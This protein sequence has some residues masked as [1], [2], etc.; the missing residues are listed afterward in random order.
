MTLQQPDTVRADWDAID[1]ALEALAKAPVLLVATDY[2]GTLAPIVDDPAQ[3][4]PI[5][6]SL[7]ALRALTALPHTHVAAVSGR[8]LADLAKLS[9]LDG[10]VML[11]GSHG[12]EFDQDFAGAITPQQTALRARLLD[13]LDRVASAGRGFSVEQ[14][15]ASIAFHYRNADPAEADRV[16]DELRAGPGSWPGVHVKTGKKVLELA[17]IHTSKGDAI[18]TIRHRVGA[19]AVLYLGDDVTDEDAFTRLRGPDVGVKVGP[20]ETAAALRVADTTD[21]ARLLA[22]LVERRQSWLAGA[23]AVP[24]EQHTLLSDGRVLALVA[25]GARLTWMCVPR[26][27]GPALFADLLGGP[28]AGHF[29]VEPTH[30]TATPTARYEGDSLVLRTDWPELSVTD[31]LDCSGGKPT[32]RAGR[33]DLIRYLEGRGEVRVTF[34]PRLDFGRIPTRLQL[35]D[36]G[37]E[38]EGTNDPIVLRA[39]GVQW[40]IVE[41]GQHQT[42]VGTLTLTGEPVR[43]EL[44]YGT[45]T[46]RQRNSDGFGERYRLTKAYWEAWADRL[47][48]PRLRPELVRR[49]ALTLKGLC[50]GPTGGIAAAATTS[51]PEDLGGVRNW[52]YRYCWPRDAALAA[53]ALVKLGS[54]NEAMALLDWMLNVLDKISAPERL[55]PL[56]TVTGH[57]V[58]AE[59]EIG[60]LAGY[61]GS[62]PVRIG[63]GARGQ[64][65]LDVFGPIAELVWQALLAEAPLSSQHW[66]LT[67]AMVAAVAARWHEP[68]H[69]I[70][71]IRKPRR[72]HTH[73][74][75]MCWLTVD[76]A[77]RVSERFL[78]RAQ[79]QWE[80]LRDEIA[81][82]IHEHA[83]NERVGAY[84][85][86]YGD[87]DLDAATLWTGLSGLIDPTSERFG[88][89]IDA[90]E[91]E[92]RDGPA[93]YRYRADD[94]LP[95]REGGFFICASWLVDAM[96]RAG[97][98]DHATRLFN[99][100][101]DLAGPTGLIPEQYDPTLARTLGNHPQAYSHIGVI[102]NALTLSS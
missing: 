29:T 42:A 35:R 86:A 95:W 99:E 8:S 3:A 68:D 6:E 97:R 85:A 55:M 94:G 59:A 14:K 21:V 18:D 19:A 49:S 73:S 51:L 12:S 78:D 88:R 87:D 34:A 98:T 26:M 41:E 15:P 27:D 22:H 93:V 5:R 46:L 23:E 92:L 74:K 47:K 66:R 4:H 89:T 72:H 48:L 17:V 64:V 10:P 61:A 62:R 70:W 52:D 79:P 56:Y 1:E 77:I 38:I 36:G 71:E 7:V 58:G 24:I 91:R 53:A 84:T 50:F 69:G 90:I 102:E 65:Q 33:T 13:E 45:G 76:R 39:P 80:S 30:T 32:Q 40:D 75:I 81:N 11:V 25:P 31:F 100:L 2:D 96:H 63:N 83:W 82:D 101:C 16:L 54:D 44:R 20:G 57:E 43:I 60:E 28:P 37:V 9:G 67:E